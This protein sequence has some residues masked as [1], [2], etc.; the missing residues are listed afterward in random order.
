MRRRLGE[1]KQVFQKLQRVWRHAR[2]N[3][4]NKLRIYKACVVSKLLYNLST[5][6]LTDSQMNQIDSFHY[7]CLLAIANIPTT[8]GAMQRGRERTSNEDVRSQLDETL[9]S[10]EIR[11]Y[12][13]KLLGHILRRP[14]R[15]PSRI[16]AFNRFLEPQ[17]LGGPFR[18]GNRRGKWAEHVIATAANIFN[19]HVFRGEGG[20]RDIKHKICGGLE[21]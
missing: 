7:R 12:Q 19:D 2:L 4:R 20:Q 13:L 21:F 8:W 1:A 5:I 3:T 11:L 10:D 9:L 6:W 18:P 14:L 17:I 15:H 16:V